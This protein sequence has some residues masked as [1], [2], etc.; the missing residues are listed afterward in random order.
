MSAPDSPPRRR[1]GAAV[2]EFAMVAPVVLFFVFALLIGGLTV[3]RYQ[4]VAHLARVGARYASTHGGR[5]QLDGIAA[6]TGVPSIAG[7]EDLR[8]YLASQT[9]LLDAA[10]MQVQVSWTAPAACTPRNLPTYINTDSSLVPPAQSVIRNYVLV[11]VTYQWLPEAL[12]AG[13][14]TV[15]STSKMPMSY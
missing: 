15:T 6:Q 2:L 8:N 7:S 3:F 4:E 5:Y 12:M 10:K 13:P 14:M 1:R 11:T 9:V